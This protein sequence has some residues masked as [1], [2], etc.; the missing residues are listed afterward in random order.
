M[1]R[2]AR[3][4]CALLLSLLPV[5]GSA[6]WFGDNW[7]VHRVDRATNEIDLNLPSDAP[8]AIA[9]NGNHGSAWALTQGD[10]FKYN[11]D[12]VTQ[13]SASLGA[14]V[15]GL[16]TSR[17]LA[18]DPRDGSVWLAGERRLVHLSAT[19]ALLARVDV[20]ATDM[21]VAQ[22]GTLWVLLPG[23]FRHY[24]SDAV[25]L[26]STVLAATDRQAKYLALDDT[27]AALWLAGEKQLTQR[28]FSDPSQIMLDLTPAETISA[29]SIDIQAG[30]LWVLGQQSLF[31]YARDGSRFLNQDLRAHGIANPQSLVFDFTAQALWV[32][33]QQGI[34]RLDLN[35]A[36]ITTLPAAAKAG[37]VAIGRLPIDVTPTLELVEP[38]PDASINNAQPT[39]AFRYGALCSSQ[40]CGFANSYFSTYSLST[41]LNGSDVGPQ[42]LF[43]DTSGLASY[44]PLMRLPEGANR[45]TGQ[46]TD[47]FGRQ[48]ETVTAAFVIDSITPQFV[49]VTPASGSLFST[50]QIT[51]EGSIDDPTAKVKLA[52]NPEVTGPT[53]SFPMTL[54]L[55]TNAVTLTATDPA[56]NS[57]TQVLT[58]IYEPPN[59]LPSVSITSPANGAAFVS[60]ATLSVSA[61]A[62]DSDGSI[63]KVEF[64]RDRI[65]VGT[66]L[67]AP[68][69]VSFT[70]SD[71]AYAL[72]AKATDNRGGTTTSQTVNVTVGPPNGLPTA[73]L[74]YP[75]SG[76]TFTAPATIHL[77]ATATDGD[78]TIDHVDF[79]RNGAVVGTT[80]TAPFVYTLT[81]VAAGT[82]TL[83]ARAVD[84]Q[85][86][87]ATST[88][89]S[90]TVSALALSFTSP[91]PGASLDGDSVLVTGTLQA[92]ANSGVIVNGVTAA[93]GSTNR[94]YALVPLVAGS[95]TLTA[96]LSAPQGQRIERSLTVSA[97]GVG[98]PFSF[99][100]EPN[101]GLA[102]LPVTFTVSNL[103]AQAATY[104]FDSFG[105]YTLPANGS[106]ILKLTYPTGVFT[107][108][109]AVTDASGVKSTQQLVIEVIDPA[110]LDQK[111]QAIWGGMNDALIAG[112]KDRALNYL[113]DG[114]QAKYGP[115]F[116]VLL[117]HMP[118]IVASYSTLAKSSLNTDYGEYAVRR[119]RG[120]KNS[121]YLIYFLRDPDGVWRLDEM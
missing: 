19:G 10:I 3:G 48:S 56:G 47:S 8:V 29:L 89:A 59:A 79:L 45:I 26:Q 113:D 78:G 109:V 96:T 107:P 33:H 64:F 25:L 57:A 34:S 93:I 40:P 60:P 27:G 31:G 97:T 118:E 16:G 87:T 12:G 100:A 70:V 73:S 14:L 58:Y 82:H 121:L 84:N 54:S 32:G 95:N 99:I 5:C 114:A 116:D 18:L 101:E 94:F 24:A 68:Y 112:D 115:V 117:P 86:G 28:S 62:A 72:T 83:S 36:L 38:Q 120:G 111:L 67:S 90:I 7:G 110:A 2:F 65:A 92:P 119:Q 11:R 15:P 102:P 61:Q 17:L 20:S 98:A 46:A 80:T 4:F 66:D 30:K 43:D 50:A 21:S 42:F 37:T 49:S 1:V 74:T 104:T 69:S 91:T 9:I 76:A 52:G 106:S 103:T 6:I 13:L 39:L 105:P 71:G 77:V 53:F 108:K 22:D 51:I 35:G 63:T 55:G 75:A 23:E 85:G 81:G 88:S 41:L 44:T